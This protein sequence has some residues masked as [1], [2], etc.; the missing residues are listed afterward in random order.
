MKVCEMQPRDAAF[1]VGRAYV[2]DLV[3]R[4]DPAI[5]SVLEGYLRSRNLRG[6]S[7][8]TSLVELAHSTELE[9]KSLRQVEAIFKKYKPLSDEEVCRQAALTSFF[10]A[11]E[12]CK[13]TNHRL[14]MYYTERGLLDPDLGEY[15]KRMESWI[16]GTL[17]NFR[18][19]LDLLPRLVRVTN[20]A[21]ATLSRAN[22][23]PFRKVGMKVSAS[24]GSTKYITALAE[25]YGVGGHVS[26]FPRVRVYPHMVNRVQ[27]VPKSWKTHRTI[28]CE[29]TGSVPLQL[30]FDS[31]AKDC[32]RRR[33]FDL[34]DQT[35]NQE[36][37]YRGSVDGSFATIDLQSASDTVAYNTVAWL[38]PTAWFRY[39]DDIR[40][41]YYRV[42]GS[43]RKYHKF[44]SMGNGTT[45]SIETL[46]FASAVRAVGSKQGA[47]YGDDIVIE[48]DLVEPLQRILAFLGFTINS[49]K[50]FVEGPFR[51]SC[52][53]DWYNGSNVTPFYLRDWGRLKTVL[54]HNVNG[55]AS[56]ARPYGHLWSLLREVVVGN[57]L[58]LV[59]ANSDTLSGVMVDAT[60][61]YNLGLV[62]T[63]LRKG[64]LVL[65]FTPNFRGYRTIGIDRLVD[66]QDSRSLLLWHLSSQ[67]RKT[68]S[69]NY[70][71]FATR[72]DAIGWLGREKVYQRSSDLP[73]H[74]KYVCKRTRWFPP[75]TG[76]TGHIHMWSD[77]LTA[78]AER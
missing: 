77:Y 16:S 30:A 45:F 51:E 19:F 58:L 3:G 31:Y 23:Q 50:S 12:Q 39:L 78:K 35:R 72:S 27:L 2:L 9:W 5:L 21:T 75:P 62:Q 24:P 60:T 25:Y 15:L 76:Y 71:K 52:G 63:S 29:P 37:A 20:G 6:L 53:S 13:S 1:A 42:D 26:I 70:G 74:H 36:L 65:P 57:R 49:E 73:L 4:I 64:R 10:E 47:V 46:I 67:G 61:A 44:S 56:I 22:S 18:D 17:G 66:P 34:R 7:S 32:L 59:P 43:I 38:F 55:L 8:C 28:A 54:S 14:D 40:T 48:T 68:P 11:E 41:S 33:G 69:A